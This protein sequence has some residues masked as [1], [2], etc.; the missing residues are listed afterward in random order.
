MFGRHC[1][2]LR[3]LMRWSGSPAVAVAVAAPMR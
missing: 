3:V 1:D 2:L